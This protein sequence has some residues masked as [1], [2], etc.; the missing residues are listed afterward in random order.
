MIVYYAICGVFIFMFQSLMLMQSK[1]LRISCPNPP[2]F[3]TE[4]AIEATFGKGRCS[5]VCRHPTPE[6]LADALRRRTLVV[7][8]F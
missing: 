2:H 1:M 6:A 7:D 5:A 3:K 4:R 8:D